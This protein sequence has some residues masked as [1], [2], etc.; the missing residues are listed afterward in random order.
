[1]NDRITKDQVS[2]LN[3][4]LVSED[5]D[6]LF[7]TAVVIAREHGNAEL[8]DDPVNA[9]VMATARAGTG[10]LQEILGVEI[11]DDSPIQEIIQAVAVAAY[12]AA[13]AKLSVA[14]G[15]PVASAGGS[16]EVESMI[17]ALIQ[18]REES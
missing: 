2:Q 10:M 5:P 1:M 11:E 6:E 8:R 3:K 17:E 15:L 9:W 7:E 4:A 14:C 16:F 18:A 12:D 13:L